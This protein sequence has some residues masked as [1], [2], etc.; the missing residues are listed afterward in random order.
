VTIERTL[1]IVLCAAAVLVL[2]AAAV[3]AT[4]YFRHARGKLKR[5]I[6]IQ[7]RVAAEVKERQTPTSQSGTQTDEQRLPMETQ[8][9]PLPETKEKPV[10]T[11]TE[12]KEK[13]A[14]LIKDADLSDYTKSKDT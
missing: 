7:E 1:F 11:E 4:L 5:I 12:I 6:R 8:T 14:P 2:A 3:F 10:L 13:R 9:P